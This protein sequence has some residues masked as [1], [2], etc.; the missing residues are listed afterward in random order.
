MYICE[1]NLKQKQKEA[2]QQGHASH[3]IEVILY[4]L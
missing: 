1:K 4:D 3:Y 2:V